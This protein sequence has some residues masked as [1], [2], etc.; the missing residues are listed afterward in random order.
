MTRHGAQTDLTYYTAH[1]P[2]NVPRVCAKG[3]SGRRAMAGITTNVGQRTKHETAEVGR[4][5]E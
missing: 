1:L 4:E 3:S 5:K 2:T